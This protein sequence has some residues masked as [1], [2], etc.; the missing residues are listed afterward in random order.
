MVQFMKA[1]EASG[2]VMREMPTDAT[3]SERGGGGGD[4][5]DGDAGKSDG[6]GGLFPL[7]PCRWGGGEGDPAQAG[8][9]PHKGGLGKSSHHLG[10]SLPFFC[11]FNPVG[12]VPRQLA[13]FAY[14]SIRV[15]LRF[16]PCKKN[17]L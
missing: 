15:K 2:G 5:G 11:I 8:Q 9:P 4:D 6:R 3:A 16:Q 1:L 13:A 14:F 10:P 17:V 7:L 12:E